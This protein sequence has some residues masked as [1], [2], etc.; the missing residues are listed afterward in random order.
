MLIDTNFII[1]KRLIIKAFNRKYLLWVL[2][3]ICYNLLLAI[4]IF[5]NNMKVNSI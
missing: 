5:S 4:L 1:G 3:G 2:G